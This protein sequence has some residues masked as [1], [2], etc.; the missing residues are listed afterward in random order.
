MGSNS[1]TM[2]KSFIFPSSHWSMH[3]LRTYPCLRNKQLAYCL[4]TRSLDR[5]QQ[6]AC[7]VERQIGNCLSYIVK[8]KRQNFYD[9]NSEGQREASAAPGLLRPHRAPLRTAAFEVCTATQ[10]CLLATHHPP[11]RPP[12]LRHPASPPPLRHPLPP[13]S[14]SSRVL[15]S[16]LCT[17]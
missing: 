16:P 10:P 17:H 5:L 3:Q 7:K 6:L 4:S 1:S 13:R 12:P 11:P 2:P 9:S 14:P 8:T 15:R